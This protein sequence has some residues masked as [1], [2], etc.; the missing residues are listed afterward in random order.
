MS[1]KL[2]NCYRVVMSRRIVFPPSSQESLACPACCVC[3]RVNTQWRAVTLRIS[4]GSSLLAHRDTM[5]AD[6]SFEFLPRF[7]NNP[8]QHDLDE[9]RSYL[10]PASKFTT[11]Q[12]YLDRL[13]ILAPHRQ[14]DLQELWWTTCYLD[15]AKK[16]GHHT[17]FR[18]LD[19]AQKL[20]KQFGECGRDYKEPEWRACVEALTADAASSSA[21]PHQLHSFVEGQSRA[22][23]LFMGSLEAATAVAIME[24][25]PLGDN[26]IRVIQHHLLGLKLEPSRF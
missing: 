2:E 7:L 14:A 21:L 11:F 19:R 1:A 24:R 16:K 4:V 9:N 10:A 8:S 23:Q 6:V 22:V 5:N 26:G 25:G 18:F 12:Q 15:L 17:D 13:K 3:V 20:Q